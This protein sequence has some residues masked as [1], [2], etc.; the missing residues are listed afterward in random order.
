MGARRTALPDAAEVDDD[1]AARATLAR[2]GLFDAAFYAQHDPALA[3]APDGGLAHWH[4]TG[5][6][7]GWKPN[8]YFETGWYLASHDEVRA[9]GLDPLL[10]YAT[11]GERHG[12]RP[13]PIFDPAWYAARHDVPD[14]ALRLAHFLGAR[15]T[16]R[17]RA[18]ALFDP[19]RYLDA[20]PDIRAA[21]M[22]PLEHYLVQGFRED[23]VPFPGFDPPFYRQRYLRDA[24]DANPLLHYLACGE[25]AGARISLPDGE[26]TIPREVRRNTAPSPFFETRV[27]LPAGSRPRARVL[28]FYLPQFHPV[29]ENDRW[30]GEG[31]T[32]W[33]SVARGLPRFAG[34]W[35]P[36]VP[37]DLG[38]YRLDG[39]SA[40]AVMRQQ[41]AFARD[42][43]IG[44]FIFY[45]YWFNRHR[46]LEGPLEALLADASLDMPFCLM[47][48]NENWT[49]RWD[50][51]DDEV[52]IRQDHRQE[53]EEALLAS[54]RRHWED[55]RYI[56]VGGRPLMMIYR[57]DAIPDT[58]ATLARWRA[59]LASAGAPA[60]LFV[61][62]QCFGADDP[63]PRGFDAAVEFPPHKVCDA[64]APINMRLDL[65]DTAFS[66]RVYDYAAIV[67]AALAPPDPPFPLL[68][69]VA[70]SWDND[71]RR[72]GA[73]IV[74]HGATP[75]RYQDWLERAITRAR[76][77]PLEGEAIVCINAWNEWAE[78]AHLEPDIHHGAAFLNATGRAIAHA[79]PRGADAG[80]GTI[81]LAGHDAL[82][83]GAQL[84]LLALATA[85]VRGHGLRIAVVLGG[86][87]PLRARF[88]ALGPVAVVDPA[89]PAR[90]DA[91]AWDA[92]I[93]RL[94]AGSG[95]FV[96]AIV[97]SLASGE[98]VPPLAARDVPTLLLAHEMPGLLAEKGLAAAAGAALAG[99]GTVVVAA[100]EVASALEAAGLAD[101]LA[102][103]ARV[104]PQGLYRPIR[105]TGAT[106]AAAR[107]RLGIGP[108]DTLVL[109][110]GYADLRKGFD[111]FLAA[112]RTRPDPSRHFVWLGNIDPTLG[113][114]LAA[115]IGAA[116][117]TGRFRL[118]PFTD[119]PAPFYAAADV[120]ALPSREDPFPSVVLEALAAG[121][122]VVAFAGAGGIPALLRARRAGTVVP[123]GDL[124]GFA[125]A[126]AAAARARPRARTA[127]RVARFD[128]YA[129]ALLRLACPALADISVAVPSWNYA[130]FM[131]ERLGSVFAQTHPVREILVLDDASTDDS[132]AVAEA[133]AAEAGR[134][135]VVH[136]RA[137]NGGSPFGQ[138]REAV[139]RARGEWLWIAEADD[140]AEPGFLAALAAR[141]AATP[142]AVLGFTDSRVVDADGRTVA[143]SYRDYYRAS[144]ADRLA[145]DLVADGPDFLRAGLAERNLILNASAVL[146]RRAALGRALDR[147]GDALSRL[148]VAGDWRVYAAMLSEPGSR[149]VFVAEPLNIHRRHPDSAT[150]QLAPRRHLREIALVQDA[151]ADTLPGFDAAARARQLAYRQEVAR[152]FAP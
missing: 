14:G 61:M 16:G 52:L 138:W 22:D 27:A 111:L 81:L 125:D 62:A 78:G 66:G 8:F 72:Q 87:G 6:R 146:F 84:L 30:W 21:G 140:A 55:P 113:T 76:A 48:A 116:E 148:R 152:G 47:W 68:R 70:P 26:T 59:R 137:R 4:R 90:P 33:N 102:A 41:I 128:R 7:L 25:A 19:A 58:A 115:E 63:R 9:R 60:P 151:V 40:A 36:R 109:G 44:G 37:R 5:W 85:L 133:V 46:L 147:A 131:A 57:A 11:E 77:R 89:A 29:P 10:H 67:E 45:Y 54:W 49:R 39:A 18:V 120:L 15:K 132:V 32:E 106:R 94:A 20:Y 142:G 114:Y 149:V 38:H 101:G 112:F 1:D 73:G 95:P 12:L 79:V 43:A 53:D 2:S 127:R 119:D 139:A 117:A 124:A 135:V 129:H 134:T 31:F 24:P 82:A 143:P 144:G 105:V 50:G 107:A 71:A 130:R 108:A 13:C 91:N 86:D 122:T 88:E 34:H 121:L 92:A 150:H 123:P 126:L 74:L 35:Q 80:A 3:D 136:R 110:V 103:R 141:L 17:V 83:H 93:A 64:L 104:L 99:A 75:A 118:I 69:T 23:R 145:A 51:S 96:A 98:A 56:R 65:L 97:N 100:R 42:A 28:A